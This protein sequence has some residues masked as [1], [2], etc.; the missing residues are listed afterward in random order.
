[1]GVLEVVERRAGWASVEYGENLQ[2]ASGSL[3]P[4][5]REDRQAGLIPL[6]TGREP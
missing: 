2:V 4:G 6:I 1:M 5:S 3:C